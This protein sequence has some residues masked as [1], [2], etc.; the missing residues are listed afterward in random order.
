MVYRLG[1]SEKRIPQCY[2]EF[3]RSN[4]RVY[5]D[6]LAVIAVV[7]EEGICPIKM[8]IHGSSNTFKRP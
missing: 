6:F 8:A 5:R 2:S 7:M 1:Q 3:I 4:E